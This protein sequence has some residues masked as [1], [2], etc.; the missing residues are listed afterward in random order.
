[1]R[2]TITSRELLALHNVLHERFEHG[3][4]KH[5]EGDPRVADEEHLRQL[6]NRVRGCI[7][8]SLAQAPFD[9]VE[10]YLDGQRAKIQDLGDVLAAQPPIQVED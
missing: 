2:L 3:I 6:H 10:G 9:P 1:M 7:I 5:E 8:G 4:D